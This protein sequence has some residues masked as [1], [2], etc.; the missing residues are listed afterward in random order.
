V[1]VRRALFGALDEIAMQWVLTPHARYGL[2]ESAEQIAE[3]FVRG[4]RCE[5]A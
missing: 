4:L 2:Q 5:A 3:I 1:I